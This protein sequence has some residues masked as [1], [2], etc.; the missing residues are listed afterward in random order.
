MRTVRRNKKPMK[1]SSY[2]YTL[3]VV[4]TDY[5]GMPQYYEDSDGERTYI[6]TGDK[7]AV[8]TDPEEMQA[9]ISFSGGE[10]QEADYGLDISQFDAV[11]L[12]LLQAYPIKEGTLIW[13][14]SEVE[15]EDSLFLTADMHTLVD[16]KVVKQVSADY[17]VKKV[18]DS[19]NYTKVNLTAVNK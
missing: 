16:A 18:N 5:N 13:T 19:L 3:D 2:L 15:Y 7:K 11:I 9:N 6:V 1:Y 17:V 14:K 12:F 10:A 4:A 8:Y